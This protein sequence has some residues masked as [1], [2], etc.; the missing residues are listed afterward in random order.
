MSTDSKIKFAIADDHKIFRDGIKM[1]LSDRPHLKLIWEA[2]DGKDMMHKLAIK[3]PDL[4]LLDIRM[5]ELDGINALPMIRQEHE[6]IR[7]VVLS[8]YDDQQMVSKMMEMGANAYLTKTT[9]PNEIYDAILT[10]MNE[11][12]Y[13]NDL[14][15]QAVLLKL[16]HKKSV[17]QFYPN[18]VKFNEK[19]LQILKFL[20]ED[21]TTEEISKLVFLSPR[22]IETIR[23]NMKSKAGVKTIAGLIVYGMRNK[24]LE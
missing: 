13:F 2:Q 20:A 16:N 7:I 18:P 5:P 6:D 4:L 11:D 22:T 1:A 17:R 14:V 10:C 8:M 3:K 15:N 19:E 24:L 21:K 23:Q 12:F 9:D